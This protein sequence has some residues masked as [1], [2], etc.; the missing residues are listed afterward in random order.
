MWDSLRPVEDGNDDVLIFKLAFK[1][2]YYVFCSFFW[3]IVFSMQ[4]SPAKL[5]R[6]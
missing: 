3:Y 5:A 1:R 6:K 4:I 2:Y